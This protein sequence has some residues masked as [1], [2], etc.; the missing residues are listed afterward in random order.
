MFTHHQ[1]SVIID[2]KLPNM[3]QRQL[4]AYMGGLD[5]C[6]GRYADPRTLFMSL[7]THETAKFVALGKARIVEHL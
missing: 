3:E 5:L 1:K 7:V 6:D 4:V 2:A